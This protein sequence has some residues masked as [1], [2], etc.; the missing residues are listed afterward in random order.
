MAKTLVAGV[1]ELPAQMP[2]IDIEEPPLP[3]AHLAGHDH[4]LD[5]GAVHQRDD[6]P[7]HVVEG[8]HIE[9]GRVE[10]DDVGLLARGEG[11]GLPGEPEVLRAVDGGEA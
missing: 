5:V 7:R 8:R 3:L 10:D 4:G 2:Q 11:S 9:R 1:L 6:R